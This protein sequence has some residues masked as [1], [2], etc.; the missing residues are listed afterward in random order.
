MTTEV[1][2]SRRTRNTYQKSDNTARAYKTSSFKEN[3]VELP[4]KK[5][6]KQKVLLLPKNLAQEK[7][8]DALENPH[9][10]IVFA[11]GYAGSGKTYI[12]TVYAIECLKNGI[13]DKVIIAR[14]NVAVDDR[15]IGFLPGDI[16]KKMAPWTKPVLDLKNIILLEK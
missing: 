6:L 5:P 2:L 3:I 15:D 13:Y 14:P 8:I 12:A 1:K 4:F 16:L 11:V 9:I 10:D 7:Y